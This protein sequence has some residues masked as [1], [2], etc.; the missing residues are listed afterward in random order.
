MRITL[1]L[2]RE[3]VELSN[4]AL[5]DPS[6]FRKVEVEQPTDAAWALYVKGSRPR[7]PRWTSDL[8]SIVRHDQLQELRSQSSSAVL[9]VEQDG[10]IFAVTFGH[11]FHAINP[12][13]VERG[14]GLRVTANVIADGR[15][16]G[17][18]TRGLS[19]AARSQKTM[20]SVAS[21]FYAL[22]VEPTEEW[23]RQLSGKVS[24]E[25]FATTA[26]GADSLRL[27]IKDFSLPRLPVK[28]REIMS[29]FRADDYQR[30]F[31]FLDNFIKLERRDPQVAE[32]DGRLTELLRAGDR[33]I[34]FAAPDPFEQLDVAFYVVRYRR[35][36]EVEQLSQEEVYRALGALELPEDA[37]HKVKIEAHDADGQL[38]DKVYDLYDYV[39]AE[40][41][42]EGVRYVL[43][44]GVWFRVSDDYVQEIKSN[45]TRIT[46]L[47]DE[48]TLPKWD[49]K[50]LDDDSSDKTAEGSYNKQVAKE[51]QFALLDKKN[52][53]IGGRYQKVEVCDLLTSAR[54]LIC[55]KRSTRSSTL[56]HLFSQAS[57]SASLMYDE[58][59]RNNMLEYYRNIG[60]TGD[61][62][63]P[64][65]W[66]FVYAIA[67]DKN[68]PL[69]ESLFF[70]SQVNLVTHARDITGRGFRVGLARIDV[71]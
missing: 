33:D 17:A 50:R 23:I 58:P 38:V 63:S 26:A 54:Q 35:K 62:G 42:G 4:E 68:G 67:T 27:T 30:D 9:L 53:S 13:L 69:A 15:I 25:A 8:R 10:R 61:F 59:Y 2:L 1:Y 70:F 71:V 31:G 18:D 57:V 19:R 29:R 7:E 55:V 46:D 41:P 28:L 45:V 16:T 49:K 48:L 36:V 52:V 11:G 6:N 5:R 34:Y 22:G 39:Q 65:N 43:A 44:S 12:N 3:G 37:L 51:R 14:F 20:L 66:T 47:T 21:E 64:S 40:L 60:G 24:T 32:L 56:S